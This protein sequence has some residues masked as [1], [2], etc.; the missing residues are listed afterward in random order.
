LSSGSSGN[1]NMP[2]EGQIFVGVVGVGAI[3][4]LVVAPS[5]RHHDND[6]NTSSAG[7]KQVA[8]NYSGIQ[9]YLYSSR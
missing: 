5:R 8:S 4:A 1:N 3:Y 6:T 9:G 2:T 7:V